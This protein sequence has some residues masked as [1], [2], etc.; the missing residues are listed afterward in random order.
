RWPLPDIGLIGGL[1]RDLTAAHEPITFLGRFGIG[2]GAFRRLHYFAAMRRGVDRD[3]AKLV[4]TFFRA[5][6]ARSFGEGADFPS[7]DFL[8][9]TTLLAAQPGLIDIFCNA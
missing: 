4:K 7:G 9:A 8:R 5:S 1:I 3:H 6:P 2:K